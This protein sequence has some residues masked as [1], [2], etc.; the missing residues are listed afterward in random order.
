MENQRYAFDFLVVK[1]NYSY[2][3]DQAKNESYHI[4]NTDVIAPADGKVIKVENQI[5]DNEPVGKMNEKHPAGNYV[6]ID[7][8]NLGYSML[9]HFK[10]KSIQVKPG[11]LVKIGDALGKVG[12]SGNSGEPHIHFQAGDSPDLEKMKSI[13][14]Q[15]DKDY[16]QMIQGKTVKRQ[17]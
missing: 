16:Y 10:N 12:N 1:D 17:Y 13:R 2:V 8:G 4:F 5:K 9:A 3:G 11:D 15:F 14:M 7:H 6:I